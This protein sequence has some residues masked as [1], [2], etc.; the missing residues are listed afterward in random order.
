[1][2]E[3]WAAQYYRRHHPYVEGGEGP[4]GYNCWGLVRHIQ[5]AHYGRELPAV[6]HDIEVPRALVREVLC[7]WRRAERPSDG[8]GVIMR[9]P[10]E[11]LH[12]GVWLDLDGGR[13]I[14]CIEGAGV[15]LSTLLHLYL[16]GFG[17]I[18]YYTPGKGR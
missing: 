10:T 3:H 18:E 14:H 4:D 8:D 11:D 13:V 17:R 15:V 2:S 16:A 7:G 1:M 5:R 6:A 9:R 12:V